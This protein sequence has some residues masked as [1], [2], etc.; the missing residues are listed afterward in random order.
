VIRIPSEL[1]Q[2]H[3]LVALVLVLHGGGGNAANAEKITGFTENAKQ[4]GFI[5]VYPEGTGRLKGKLLTW[6]AG[7]C[8]GYA[9]KHHVNDV[10][11]INFI[12]D[13]LV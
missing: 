11:F 8:C 7:P 6:N 1:P 4:E 5:V 3:G 9:M 2:G 13:K 10:G 12:I